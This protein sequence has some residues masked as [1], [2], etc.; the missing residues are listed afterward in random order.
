M[1]K[2]EYRKLNSYG[3]G[4][5]K[6]TCCAPPPGQP[7]KKSK[8]IARKKLNLFRDLLDKE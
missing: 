5:W 3:P 7:K 4:G 2:G 8:R 6:C 1:S